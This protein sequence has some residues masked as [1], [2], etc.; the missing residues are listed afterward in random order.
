MSRRAGRSWWRRIRPTPAVLLLLTVGLGITLATGVRSG[1]GT[2]GQ[3]PRAAPALAGT[4]LTGERFDLAA[5]RGHVVVVNVFASWCGPCRDELPMLVETA[6]Q[7]SPQG[8][9]VVGLNLRDG[10][11]AVRAL[12]AQ[13][14][15]DDLTVLPDPDGTRAVEWGVRGVPETF[16]VDRDGRIVAHQ[17]GVVTGQWLREH[18]SPL[19]AA[20]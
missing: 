9:R 8:L 2:A 7:W 11:D 14:H 6:R 10:P 13:A 19:L 3:Q 20:A 5:A 4:T 12:L 17:P 1:S 15:A 18:L 16:V